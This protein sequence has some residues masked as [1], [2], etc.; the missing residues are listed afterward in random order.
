MGLTIKI[1]HNTSK[2]PNSML[3]NA[4]V[5]IKIYKHFIVLT[6]FLKCTKLKR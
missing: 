4:S 5:F 3:Q 2:V 6:I 1:A